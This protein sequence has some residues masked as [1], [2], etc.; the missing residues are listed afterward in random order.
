MSE[1]LTPNEI[2]QLL[3]A[4]KKGRT[5]RTQK[6]A[7]TAPPLARIYD[8]RHPNLA[9]KEH[10]SIIQVIHERFSKLL[11]SYFTNKLRAVIDIKLTAVSQETYLEFIT[12]MSDPTCAYVIHSKRLNGDAILEISPPLVFF[13]VDRLFGGDGRELKAL[14]ELTLIEQQVMSKITDTIV[15]TL[16]HAWDQLLRLE[17]SVKSFHNRPS[18]IQLAPM[19]EAM[20]TVKLSMQIGKITGAVR[21]CFPFMLL[22]DALPNF[23]SQ[24]MV[25][26]KGEKRTLDD[27]RVMLGKLQSA[28]VP[29][30][31]ILGDTHVTFKE[32]A[33]LR[34]GDVLM[35]N[36]KISEDVKI[37]VNGVA[38]FFAR[39][40]VAGTKRALQITR[41]APPQD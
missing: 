18:F 30:K 28:T 3:E 26:A 27:R 37:L 29:V 21:L 24:Q 38:K 22:E 16:N 10:L 31:S 9:S 11:E 5:A 35:L 33:N 17:A 19:E 14:R 34:A 12:S 1:I 6:S 41:P 13:I 32:L 8:F 2:A 39:P 15:L 25:Y 20:I 4:V 23:S 36:Q 40:G 7:A